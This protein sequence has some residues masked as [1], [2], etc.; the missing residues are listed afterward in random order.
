MHRPGL[1]PPVAPDFSGRRRRPVGR[2]QP[3]LIPGCRDLPI[4]RRTVRACIPSAS[5][6]YMKIAKSSAGSKPAALALDSGE[7]PSNGCMMRSVA[8]NTHRTNDVPLFV[9]N[10]RGRTPSARLTLQ[11]WRTRR[12]TGQHPGNRE[13][14]VLV[15]ACVK[16]IPFS[17]ALNEGHPHDVVIPVMATRSSG[18]PPRPPSV[19]CSNPAFAETEGR[20]GY[21]GG[22]KPVGARNNPRRWTGG[23]A[24]A[25]ELSGWVMG[26]TMFSAAFTDA[27]RVVPCDRGTGCWSHP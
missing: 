1:S 8:R 4:H 16:I 7:D 19:A 15:R 20:T 18:R 23:C 11:R 27:R 2:F 6:Q 5:N 12:R 10:A 22:W 25:D 24:D 17:A 26:W 3:R 9:S 13:A 14:D 21:L